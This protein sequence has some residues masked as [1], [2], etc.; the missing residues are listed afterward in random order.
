M[1]AFPYHGCAV[2]YLTHWELV[3][4][5]C[6][7]LLG[8]HANAHNSPICMLTQQGSCVLYA[9]ETWS[10]QGIANEVYDE[11]TH[12]TWIVNWTRF[13]VML[14]LGFHQQVFL[15]LSIRG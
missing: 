8:T 6:D 3:Q 7:A 13:Q 2:P 12:E 9:I 5:L 1:D 10:P 15:Y 11:S 14:D 4:S